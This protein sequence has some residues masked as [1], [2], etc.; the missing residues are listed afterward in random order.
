[1]P[2]IL[3]SLWAW[4][5]I[6]V[7]ILLW[8]PLLA[9]LRLFDRDPVHYRTGRMFRRLGVAMTLVNPAWRVTVSGFPIPRERTPYVVVSNHQSLADIPLISHLPWEMKWIGKEELF[10]I[11][12]IGWMMRLSSDISVNRGDARSG[13]KTLIRALRVLESGC[14]VIFFPEGTRSPDGRVGRFTDGAFHLAIRARVP[15]LPIVVEGSHDAL[16]KRSWKF[17]PPRQ[18][19][20]TVLEPVAVEQYGSRDVQGLRD[21]VRAKILKTLADSRNVEV[22]AVDALSGSGVPE[23]LT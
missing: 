9:L 8:L 20:I 4:G 12:V 16:P 18:I 13:A 2:S 11:P 22:A 23:T 14:P 19:Q 7:L 10:K 1:M 3:R 21:D 17:G 5:A 6:T 15:V